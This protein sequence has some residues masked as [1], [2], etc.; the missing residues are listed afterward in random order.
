[1][2]EQNRAH[3]NAAPKASG[4]WISAGLCSWRDDALHARWWRAATVFSRAKRANLSNNS[5]KG[6]TAVSNQARLMLQGANG[7]M[8]GGCTRMESVMRRPAHFLAV[9]RRRTA[10]STEP[11][12]AGTGFGNRAARKDS[13]TG[14]DCRRGVVVA[15]VGQLAPRSINGWKGVHRHRRVGEDDTSPASG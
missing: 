5:L 9:Q 8:A 15:K 12:Y 3:W 2:R 10:A 4:G 6:P 1:M 7:A 13:E 14:H 11:A